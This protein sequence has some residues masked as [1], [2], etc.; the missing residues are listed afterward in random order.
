VLAPDQ[1]LVSSVRSS[2]TLLPTSV[3]LTW[4]QRRWSSI[5]GLSALILGIG[6]DRGEA[7]GLAVGPISCVIGPCQ[8]TDQGFPRVRQVEGS[9]ILLVV[10]SDGLNG[11]R[12]GKGL[13]MKW[14]GR[15]GGRGPRTTPGDRL[16]ADSEAF[17]SGDY[18]SHLRRQG[19]LV[20]GWAWLNV[21]A[22]GDLEDL[23]RASVVP[24]S[25]GRAHCASSL[26]N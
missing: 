13:D 15:T 11:R 25:H 2:Q 6:R 23:R 24:I 21:I 10:V 5:Q 17:L 18:A 8:G 12:R 7:H 14:M 4:G 19:E 16:V 9:A 1:R 26:P 3:M 20:P 22:H